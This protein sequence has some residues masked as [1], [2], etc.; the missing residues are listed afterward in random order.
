MTIDIPN[1]TP[2][3]FYVMYGNRE[4]DTTVTHS[5]YPWI[6]TPRRVQYTGSGRMNDIESG[7]PG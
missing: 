5:E 2:N 1:S 3:L 7:L 4:S 6:L